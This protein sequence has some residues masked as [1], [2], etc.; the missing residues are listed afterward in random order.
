MST[1][2]V[3]SAVPSNPE[4]IPAFLQEELKRMPIA[5][6]NL[7]DGHI[8]KTHVAP[9]KPRDGDFR[10]ADGT[11][12]NPGHGRGLYYYDGVDGHWHRLNFTH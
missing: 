9:D 6:N 3:P 8:D 12:W 2:Y 1:R 7:S 4:D 11:N 5:V 10:F